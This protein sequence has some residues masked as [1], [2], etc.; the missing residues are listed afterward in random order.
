MGAIH[1]LA[2]LPHEYRSL[3]VILIGSL[4]LFRTDQSVVSWVRSSSRGL[5]RPKYKNVNTGFGV[6]PTDYGR[7]LQGLWLSFWLSFLMITADKMVWKLLLFS[8]NET[9]PGRWITSFSGMRLHGDVL[10]TNASDN[11]VNWEYFTYVPTEMG[12]KQPP[13]ERLPS[14]IPHLIQLYL[15]SVCYRY[16]CVEVMTV[17][18]KLSFFSHRKKPW[19]GPGP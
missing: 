13:G 2:R 3:W 8:A 1:L 18:E 12:V 16:I 10:C 9:A 17:T 19:A 15:Y 7:M 6:A 14:I 4:V 5:F 11:K